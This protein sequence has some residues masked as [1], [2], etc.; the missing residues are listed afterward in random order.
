MGVFFFTIEKDVLLIIQKSFPSE[1]NKSLN[2]LQY[3]PCSLYLY[4]SYEDIIESEKFFN[5][6]VPSF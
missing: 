5:V 4:N 1:I 3:V 6:I 2:E